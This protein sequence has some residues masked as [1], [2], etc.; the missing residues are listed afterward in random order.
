L[1]DTSESLTA[2]NN[3]SKNRQGFYQFLSRIFEKEVDSEFLVAIRDKKNFFARPI[4]GLDKN[5]TRGLQ[6]VNSYLD[7]SS[8]K[9]SDEIC[10]ELAVEYAGLFL[11]VWGKPP[12]PSES[13]YGSVGGLVMQKERDEVLILYNSA[14]LVLSKNFREPEDHVAIELQF[15]SYLAGETAVA[16]NAHDSKKVKDLI[17]MQELFLK[18]HLGRWLGFMT[19]D[20]LEAGHVDFYKGICLLTQGFVDE[21]R[22][23]IEEL[24]SLALT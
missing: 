11:G 19:H 7:T 2:L 12:H 17:E 3:L 8:N 6:L 24:K 1:N 4:E 13:I 23:S 14:G 21:D 20:V 18:K 10:L 5:M 22:K 15:M 16:A 9:S